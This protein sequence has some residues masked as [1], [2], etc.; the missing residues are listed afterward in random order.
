MTDART[1]TSREIA[2][3]MIIP[4]RSDQRRRNWC[5]ATSLCA[6][7]R[8]ILFTDIRITLPSCNIAASSAL[9]KIT[10]LRSISSDLNTIIQSPLPYFYRN[11]YLLSNNSYI[12]LFGSLHFYFLIHFFT[13]LQSKKKMKKLKGIQD[14]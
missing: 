2:A 8:A 5:P 12:Q 4:H 11:D 14:N 10:F 13:D 1:K 3:S 6:C 9:L 7:G